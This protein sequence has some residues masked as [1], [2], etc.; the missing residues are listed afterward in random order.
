MNEV[1]W[2]HKICFACQGELRTTDKFCRHC[3]I[4][5]I[6]QEWVAQCPTAGIRNETGP[7]AQAITRDFSDKESGASA[8][9]TNPLSRPVSGP[10][11]NAVAHGMALEQTISGYGRVTRNIILA[12]MSVPVWL[13]IILL[14]PLDAWTT[15]RA[16]TRQ[17]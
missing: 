12:L 9:Q 13:M 8:Y 2:P 11:L 17:V 14:S 16:I 3:G 1:N 7:R 4:E 6:S 15:T 10:L 5:L